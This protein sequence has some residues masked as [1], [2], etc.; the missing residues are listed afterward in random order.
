MS[1]ITTVKNVESSAAAD[2]THEAIAATV[3]P[4]TFISG[5]PYKLNSS[6]AINPSIKIAKRGAPTST[7]SAFTPVLRREPSL[8]QQ[9]MQRTPTYTTI[10]STGGNDKNSMCKDLIMKVD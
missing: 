3:R 8:K 7:V 2:H 4:T 9:A 6:D 5:Q 1:T 10:G